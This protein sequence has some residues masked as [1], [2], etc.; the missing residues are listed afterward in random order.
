[1][2]NSFDCRC[3]LHGKNK[4]TG[5]KV[6]V[7]VNVKTNESAFMQRRLYGT[8]TYILVSA[9]KKCKID[10]YFSNCLYIKYGIDN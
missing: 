4:K 1:M 10:K 7:D 5:T 2:S 8:L 9:L 3:R 6:N